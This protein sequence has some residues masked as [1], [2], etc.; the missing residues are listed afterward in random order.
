MDQDTT[1]VLDAIEQYRRQGNHTFALPGHRL[2]EG[3]DSA[4]P[5]CCQEVRSRPM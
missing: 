4:P 2:G 3:I 5:P 1:P